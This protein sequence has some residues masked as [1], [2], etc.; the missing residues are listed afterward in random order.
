MQPVTVFVAREIA[1]DACRRAAVHEHEMKHVEVYETYLRD[2]T[3]TLAQSLPELV[4]DRIY[5]AADP[6]QAQGELQQTLAQ[7]LGDFTAK[8]TEELGARQAAVDSADEYARV[9]NACG[10]AKTQ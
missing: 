4:G 1:G 5:Y 3:G 6:T 7:F 9:A 2:A 8:S 10:G